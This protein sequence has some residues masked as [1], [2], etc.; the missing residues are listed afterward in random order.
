MTR[1]ALH[2]AQILWP[3]FIVAGILE[4]VVFAWVDPQALS[5]GDVQLTAQAVYTIAFFVFWGLVAVSAELSHWMIR[6]ND[7]QPHSAVAVSGKRAR[8]AVKSM[9]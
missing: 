7:A 2:V 4:M 8:R 6:S 3:A 9:A 5:L 1:R